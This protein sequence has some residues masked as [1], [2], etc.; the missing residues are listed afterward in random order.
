MNQDG[1]RAGT[2]VGASLLFLTSGG[3]HGE[4]GVR[5]LYMKM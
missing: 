4:D 2:G 3:E 5:I 1:R